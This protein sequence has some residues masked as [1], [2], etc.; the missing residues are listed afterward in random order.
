LSDV[1]E[2]VGQGVSALVDGREVR[3]GSRSFVS[4][5]RPAWELPWIED[6]DDLESVTDEH[7]SAV[8]VSIDGE[9]VG[10]LY[11]RSRIRPGTAI[12]LRDL[13]EQHA[14]KMVSG[15]THRRQ[16]PAGDQRT[17]SGK[18]DEPSRK[19]GETIGSAQLAIYLRKTSISVRANINVL[20]PWSSRWA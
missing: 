18:L 12:M 9:V 3:I 13:R 7:K 2:V 4:G 6:A 8:Y 17:A 16:W 15:D 20:D 1:N 11:V 10:G 14:L 19:M 5:E